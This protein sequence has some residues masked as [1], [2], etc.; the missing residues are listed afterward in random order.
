MGSCLQFDVF[1]FQIRTSSQSENKQKHSLDV[2]RDPNAIRMGGNACYY[3]LISV[4]GAQ[5]EIL[6]HLKFF[7]I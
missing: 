5:N 3:E 7:G 4:D 1:A 6:Q 2:Y